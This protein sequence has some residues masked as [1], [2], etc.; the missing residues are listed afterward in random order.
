MA[1]TIIATQASQKK[2][3]PILTLI[4]LSHLILSTTQDL[5]QVQYTHYKKKE[6]VYKPYTFF[7]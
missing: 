4:I 1:V 3:T 6:K 7:F 5:S 2:T